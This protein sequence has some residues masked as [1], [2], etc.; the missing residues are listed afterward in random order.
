MI[1]NISVVIIVIAIQLICSCVTTN[2][3]GSARDGNIDGIEHALNNGVPIDKRED[4][5]GYNP[6]SGKTA[7]IVAARYGHHEAVE[8]LCQHGANVNAQDKIKST[9][10]HYAAYFNFPEVVE[11]LLKYNADQ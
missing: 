7:L 6:S 8:Y 3:F 9:A 4:P 1:R 5:R 11:V 10:L 2:I